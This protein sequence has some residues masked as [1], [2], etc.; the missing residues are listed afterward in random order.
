MRLVVDANRLFAA[1]IKDSTTRRIVIEEHHNLYVPEF[2]LEE[3]F[4]HTKEIQAK[5]GLTENLIRK[6]IDELF[7][8]GEI[9]IITSAE[10]RPFLGEA[11]RICP[12]KKDVPYFALA[13][14]LRCPIWSEDKELKKQERISVLST[15]ELLDKI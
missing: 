13:L 6:K 11:Q 4:K 15:K 8:L 5:T 7:V 3:L 9:S 2:I 10:T 12:D 1:L 14:K